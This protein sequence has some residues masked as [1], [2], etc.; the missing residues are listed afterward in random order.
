LERAGGETYLDPGEAEDFGRLDL[1]PDGSRVATSLDL[2]DGSGRRIVVKS[3]PDGPLSV[4]AESDYA[5][6]GGTYPSW[7]PTGRWI[8]F[9]RRTGLWRVPSDG[10]APAELFFETD[11]PIAESRILED[12]TLILRTFPLSEEGR[13]IFVVTP[14]DSIPR[15]FASSTSDESSPVLSPDG[16]WMAYTSGASATNRPEVFI[17]PFP[18]GDALYPVSTDGG[19]GPQWAHSGR[20]LFFRSPDGDLMVVDVDADPA[21]GLRLSSPRVLF[22]RVRN[23]GANFEI[24]P[25]DQSFLVTEPVGEGRQHILVLNFFEELKRRVPNR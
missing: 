11:L 12:G 18:G 9:N 22:R 10:S 20:E 21:D 14:G 23:F 17:R 4:I 25:D 2:P 1:S 3:L 15:P 13:E 24:F 5:G 8:Y 16:R 19:R 7:D 6:G